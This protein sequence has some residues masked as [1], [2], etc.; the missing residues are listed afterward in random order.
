MRD[1]ANEYSGISTSCNLLEEDVDENGDLLPPKLK[2]LEVNL[3]AVL[4]TVKLA[5]HYLR[6]EGGSIVVTGSGSSFSRFG[7]TD[8]TTSKHGVFGLVRAMTVNLYP[9]I[10]IRINGLAPAWTDT[11]I[12]PRRLIDALGDQVQ[13]ADVVARSAVLL[14]ADE[15]RHGEMIFSDRGKFWDVENGDN[16][17]IVSLRRALDIPEQ[18]EE[19][20]IVKLREARAEVAKKMSEEAG[21]KAK[22]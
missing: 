22:S 12:I 21:T 13:S 20:W 4:Y 15:T 7:P 16:G 1:G 3:I 14:M 6:K 2:T 11:N 9:N 19:P 18:P 10:P 5:V 17:L 8:Y